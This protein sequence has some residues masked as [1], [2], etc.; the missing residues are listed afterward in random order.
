MMQLPLGLYVRA[1]HGL[2]GVTCISQTHTPSEKRAEGVIDET[3]YRFSDGAVVRYSLEQDEGNFDFSAE[4]SACLPCEINYQVLEHP[5]HGKISPERKR[6]H[7]S[8]R[9]L[10]WLKMQKQD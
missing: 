10:F 4:S 5:G 2:G 9:H 1:L 8:C 3:V 7:N 6:F